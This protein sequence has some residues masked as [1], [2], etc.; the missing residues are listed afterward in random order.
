MFDA[1]ELAKQAKKEEEEIKKKPL[2]IKILKATWKF[3]TCNRS[4]FLFSEDSFVRIFANRV[5]VWGPFEWS[6][7]ATILCTTVV[8][9]AEDHLPNN[10]QTPLSLKLVNLIYFKFKN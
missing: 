4:L 2:I 6:I 3:I 9:A 8:M 10:D 5:I 7:L 1:I